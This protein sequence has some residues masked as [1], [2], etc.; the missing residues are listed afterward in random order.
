MGTQSASHAL[1]EHLL[2]GDASFR[3]GILSALTTLHRAHP[4]LKSDAQLL[5]MALAA[6]ILGH[7]RSYQI[8]ANLSTI[9]AGTEQQVTHALSES[10]KQE[11]ERIFRLLELLYP[12]HDF[13]SAYVGL[14]S[15]SMTVHDNALEFLDTVLKSELRE[16]LVPLLDGKVSVIERARIG[17]RLVHVRIDNSEQAAA[18]LV[19]SDDPWLR[20][21]G[22]YAIG[23]LGLTNLAHELNRCVADPDPL[24]R[25]TA[26]EAKLRLQKRHTVSA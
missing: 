5:E 22:A 11:M 15:K 26:R 10:M 1:M 2:D 8:L 6:E 4:E 24:V 25:E 9:A 7:Y 16:M 12:H 19:S 18:A 21:C 17:D 14:Q 20:S 3:L 13:S 23:T